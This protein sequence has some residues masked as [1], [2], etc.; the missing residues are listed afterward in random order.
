MTRLSLLLLAVG[1]A[2]GLFAQT[3][4][5]SPKPVFAQTANAPPKPEWVPD[6]SAGHYDCPDG[7]TEYARREPI[8]PFYGPVAA[9][10]IPPNTDKNGHLIGERPDP[11][12]CIKDKP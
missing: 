10:F 6:P 3:A 2:S 4:N 1:M 5:V 9:I 7:W 11:G 12:I 8:K